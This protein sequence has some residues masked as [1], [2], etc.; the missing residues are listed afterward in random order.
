VLPYEEGSKSPLIIYDPRLPQEY[1]GTTCDA[2]TANVDMAATVL[3][4]AG[5]P[6]AGDIDGRN[7]VPLLTNPH[8]P[9][10]QFLPLFNFWGIPS[11][12]SMAV[13]TEDWKYIHWYYVGERMQ[14]TDELFHLAQDR[15]EMHNLA[16]DP[17]HA[18][19]LNAMREL[20][21][22][23]LRHIESHAVPGHDYKR[24]STLFSRTI[25]WDQKARLFNSAK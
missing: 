2:V 1:A 25:P 4:L 18:A 20:Y 8:E 16:G 22:L 11:A 10:R 6:A 24:Y 21:D 7:L 5:V 23:Q 19:R 3:A 13:V 9:V 15:L 14:P 17:Q 12:Q